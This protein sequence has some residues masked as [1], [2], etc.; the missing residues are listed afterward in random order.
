MTSSARINFGPETLRDLDLACG[1]EWLL[2]DGL[3]GYASSTP[4]GLNT[5][6][7]HGLLVAATRPP[8][9]RMVLLSQL[10]EAIVI[11]GVRQALSTR[12][13]ADAVDPRGFEAAL[14][15]TLDPLPTLTWQVEGG[16][17]SRSITRVS[18]SPA[19]A[20]VYAYDGTSPATL[21]LRPL[22][23]YRDHHAL[24][25]ENSAVNGES[26]RDGP[27]VVLKPY[28]GCPELRLRVPE[29][30]F[31]PDA[32]WYRRFVYERE[33]ERGYEFEEDLFS[34]GRFVVRLYAGEVATLVAWAGPMPEGAE[35]VDLA[36]AERERLRAAGGE[37]LLGRLRRA[38][39]AFVVGDARRAVIAG[40]P[41]L[42]ERGRDAMIALPGLCLARRR[43]SEARDILS[44][45]ARRLDAGLLA[46][47]F[48]ETGGALHE[49]ADASLWFVLAVQ[50]CLEAG[51]DRA[52]VRSALY[53]AVSAILDAYRRG[54][55]YGIR[56]TPD[57]LLTQ[58][59]ARKALTWMDARS[60]EHCITARAGEAVELQ[61]LWYNALLSA[62]GLAQQAG[63]SRR[64]AE[65]RRLAR[66]AHDELP[67]PA[68]GPSPW[69]TWRT[70]SATAPRTSRCA[71]TS[72]SRSACRTRCCRAT[73]RRGSW[74]SCAGTCSRRW[75]CARSPRATPPIG[76][77]ATATARPG[78]RASPPGDGVALAD[79]RLLR[80]A[81]ERPWRRR[82]AA[83]RGSGC[84]A[85]RPIS[86]K[87][88]WATCRE[89]FDGDAPHR[90][91][92]L[93]RPGLER[94]RAAARR[95]G[96]RRG[97][98]RG[99]A[100]AP[101]RKLRDLLQQLLV[102]CGCGR[103]RPPRASSARRPSLSIRK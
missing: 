48:P 80:C 53:G 54:T 71:P 93:D 3:G 98:R 24:Q 38:A 69:A 17:L 79:G 8:L 34:H 39:D 22:I 36:D 94:G 91:R 16:T 18:G 15:F 1:R 9:G 100:H 11:G 6:R 45:H 52:F 65:W 75:A 56:M 19:S 88:A 43:M 35:G 103:A 62:A 74:R 57:G 4:I 29:G 5:R 73:R 10:D 49:T 96:C 33:R 61:A 37:D 28:S 95:R 97:R 25:R 87:R 7:Y 85:S 70:W 46:S 47:H 99:L 64:S 90:S 92:R 41:W 60:G 50:R 86:R 14:A 77:A 21:E 84:A 12:A 40:Y 83:R 101:S 102:R 20:L 58:G 23:A 55:R 63:D 51:A 68:S 72:S 76:A 26:E 59:E 89:M 30:E 32:C 13:H 82:A 67:A 78:P 81:R 66:L 31:I 44:E 27:D 2:P 42:P